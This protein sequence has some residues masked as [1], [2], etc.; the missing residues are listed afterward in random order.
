MPRLTIITRACCNSRAGSRSN[1][2]TNRANAASVDIRQTGKTKANPWPRRSS[3]RRAMVAADGVAWLANV[4]AMPFTG[5]FR[6]RGRGGRRR[7]SPAIQSARRQPSRSIPR[8]P[9]RAQRQRDVGLFP[10]MLKSAQSS[11]GSP[12]ERSLRRRHL[13]GPPRTP[14]PVIKGHHVGSIYPL[15]EI[16]AD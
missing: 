1:R 11:S 9:L 6:R 7:W 8:S 13:R 16:G 14:R 2:T 15:Y 10:G 3:G 12:I 5:G 4:I